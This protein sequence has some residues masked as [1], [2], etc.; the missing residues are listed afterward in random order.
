MP[1]RKKPCEK[2]RT[3]KGATIVF[4]LD[5]TLVDSA[6]DLTNALNDVL[7]RR[8]HAPVR[9]EVTRAS[10]GRGARIMIEAAL[11][12]AGIEDDVDAM[13]AEFLVH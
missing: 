11:A 8:G 4:D 2:A 12:T 13:L 1:G 3:F 9:L 5:G 6:P 7:R 10:V